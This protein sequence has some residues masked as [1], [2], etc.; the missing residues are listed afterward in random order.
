MAAQ[1]EAINWEGRQAAHRGPLSDAMTTPAGLLEINVSANR[2]CDRS[3]RAGGGN[4][5]I[6]AVAAET[7]GEPLAA[8]ISLVV[9]AGLEAK[10][11]GRSHGG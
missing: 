5:E 4:L 3:N 7:P 6:E 2:H 10:A 9:V 11:A 1:R 8:E